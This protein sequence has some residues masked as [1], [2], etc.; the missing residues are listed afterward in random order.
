VFVLDNRLV[1]TLK[2]NF[3]FYFSEMVHRSCRIRISGGQN[4]ETALESGKPLIGTS[5][6]GM[7]MMVLASLRKYVDLD[8]VVTIIPDD[9]RG[10]ILDIFAK[11]LGIYPTR[12]NLG[13]DTTMGM[14]RKLVRVIREITSGKN[15]LIHPDGPEGPAYKVKPGLTAIAQKTGAL[16]VPMGGYCR[17]AYHWH[18]WDRYTWPLPFSRIQLHVGEPI[19]IPKE[20]SGLEDINLELERILN[21]VAFQAAEK[22]YEH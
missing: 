22:Y 16:I 4:M 18:R 17:N 19:L 10:D 20:T 14:S 12:L 13:G 6:H 5:W 11:R 9:H 1:I 15:F 8:S 3:L 2:G 21:R 7:T